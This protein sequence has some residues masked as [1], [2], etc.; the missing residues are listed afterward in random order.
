MSNKIKLILTI[1]A[2]AAIGLGC[3]WFATK[4]LGCEKDYA[5]KK[6]RIVIDTQTVKRYSEQV[7]RDTVVKFLEKVIYK[8][9]E[10]KIIYKQHTDTIF[11]ETMKKKDVMIRIEKDEEDM[12]IY[13]Y[14]EE[15]GEVKEYEFEDVGED[16]IA[17]SV[18]GNIMMQSQR[19]DWTGVDVFGGAELL[20][21]KLKEPEYRKYIIGLVTGMK[22]KD[23]KL[24]LGLD[25]DLNNK[26]VKTFL[27]LNYKLFK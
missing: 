27:K 11:R 24:E 7:K 12:S 22:Y 13:A 25:M 8:Q 19:F 21:F 26:D 14:N 6:T 3:W 4:L 5:E 2:Y 20:N 1:I 9:L 10:P 15:A 17:T 16:F 18:D 23:L